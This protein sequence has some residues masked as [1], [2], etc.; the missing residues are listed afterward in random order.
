MPWFGPMR[1]NQIMPAD[2]REWVTHLTKNKVRPSNLRTLKS[3]L[4]AVFTT[5]LNDQV[6]FLHP[7]KDPDR[8]AR[9]ADDRDPGTVRCDL[10][11]TS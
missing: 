10:P 5:A 11:G 6:A 9:V 2:V 7:C 3:I 8:S 4:S 1:M